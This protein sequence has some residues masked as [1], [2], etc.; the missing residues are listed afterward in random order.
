MK[1][2]KIVIKH[3]VDEQ[4]DLSYLGVYSN[5]PAD[6]CIDREERG[7]QERNEF[8][9]FNLGCGD[10]DYIEQDYARAESYNRQNWC[11]LGIIAEAE[12]SYDIGQGC[13]RLEKLSSGGIWGIESDS[14]DDYIEDM[15]N[16]QLDDLRQ[17]LRHFGINCADED[18]QELCEQAKNNIVEV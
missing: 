2:E 11:M 7:D 8:R 18:W 10:K 5:S 9:Y 1:I 17:H 14:D 13:R 4:P 15:Q 16:E 3:V 12:M 6:V